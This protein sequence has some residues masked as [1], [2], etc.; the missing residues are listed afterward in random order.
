MF[1][2]SISIAHRSP[3]SIVILVSFITFST[4]T[5]LLMKGGRIDPTKPQQR[6]TYSIESI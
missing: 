6:L 5:Q 4:A 1:I 2:R 3:L